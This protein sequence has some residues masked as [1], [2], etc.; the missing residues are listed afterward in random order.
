MS[1]KTLL[2]VVLVLAFCMTS[3]CSSKK[4]L[5]TAADNGK[6]IEANVGDQIVVELDGNPSTGYTWEAK[7]LDTNMIQQVGDPEFK[8]NNPGLIGSG[9]VLTMTFKILKAG[10]T[11]LT[12]FYQ[13]P[14][15]TDVKPQATF[16]IS[17]VAK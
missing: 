12:L 10:T 14:W 5:L 7:D 13:R 6:K 2:F 9:G 8:S 11:S 16:V 15:E 4:A 3:G 17:L 1:H